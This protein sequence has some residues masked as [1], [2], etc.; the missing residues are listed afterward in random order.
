MW[1]RILNL[2]VKELQQLR[3]D[4]AA[5]FRLLIPTLVQLFIFG[6]AA[7]FEVYNV[8]TIVLDQD[9]SQESRE[10]VARFAGSGRFQ[11]VETANSA[12]DVRRAIDHADAVVAIVIQAGF[13]D[14]VRKGVSAPAQVIV[15]GTNS[16]TA[17]IAL[18]YVSRIVADYAQEMEQDLSRRTRAGARPPPTVTLESRPW[19]NVDFNSRWFFVPGVIATLTLIMIVNLTSFAVVREREV[20]TLEQIMVT[21]IRPLEF[22]LGKTIP[23]F[24]VGLALVVVIAGVG[25]LWFQIPF[26]GN[27]LVLLL[28]TALYLLCVL[29]IGLLISTVCKTQQQAFATNFFVINPAFILSG[30]SFPIAS[31]PDFMQWIS[32]IN[33]MTYYL[34]VIRGTFLKGVGLEVLWPQMLAL[35]GLGIVLLASSVLRFRKS[36]D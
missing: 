3:R 26:R 10:L 11:I 25:T 33:P 35:A 23:Y 19:Y 4:R 20:G 28:G 16:N 36:L 7:T 1:G 24:L 8:A 14:D 21:P 6:Y 18:S 5:K 27:P 31:M 17:L 34:V 15:D 9:H 30:F 12:A 2:V 32:T 13:A 22:I 29:G